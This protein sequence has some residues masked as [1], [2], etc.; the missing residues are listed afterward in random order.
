MSFT[1][2][3]VSKIYDGVPAL[4]RVSFT[5]E[6]GIYGLLG[7]NGA[8]KTTFMRIMT[9]LLVP[10]TGRVMLGGKDIAA[11][12]SAFRDKLGYLPQD[13]GVYPNFTAEMFIL[14]IAKL[15]GLSKLVAE[16]KT[17]EL[18]ELVGLSDKKE[19]KLGGFSGG[20]RQRIGIAQALLNDPQILILDEPT[21]GLD[22]EERIRFRS[23]LS[24]LSQNKT[25]L[26]STHIVSDIEAIADEVILL[27]NGRI[28]EMK[29]PVELLAALNGKV[30]TLTL[31]FE[32]EAIMTKQYP[33]SNITRSD[34]NSTIRLISD[35]QPHIAALPARPNMEDMYLYF[36]GMG[37]E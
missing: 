4:D 16:R 12:G 11:L 37:K 20:Q 26:L 24:S 8:G 1:V 18:L 14:Y 23:I 2:E 29:K 7:P 31:P 34:G 13:F 17:D 33:C 22:P 30:W 3:N 28:M 27:N 5:L 32:D 25:I 10:S 21:A 35:T 6:N 36:F 19:K 15:K 9:D